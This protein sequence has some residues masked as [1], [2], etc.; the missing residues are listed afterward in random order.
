MVSQYSKVM[1]LSKWK[2]IVNNRESGVLRFLGS[3]RVTDMASVQFS[4]PVISDSLGTHEPQDTRPPCPLPLLES[5]Q[6]LVHWVGEAIQPSHPLS[7]PSPPAFNLSQ[8]PGLFQWVSS[9][10]QVATVLEFQLQ[11][12][13][14]QWTPRTYRLQDGLVGSPCSPRDSQESSPTP[15]FK[16]INSSAMSFLY[17]PTLTSIHDCWKNYSLW[18]FVGKVMSLLFNML[19]RLVITFLPRNKYPLISWQQSP[20]AVLEPKKIKPLT[21][22]IVSS[23]ICQKMMRVD[24][25]IFVFWML[26]FKP[27]FSFPSFT[28]IKRLFSSSLLSAVRVVSSVYLRLLVF[29]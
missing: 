9:S 14:V 10:C 5:T 2:D 12:Q 16:S 4:H 28:F 21:V 3:H 15:Q 8:H 27:T 24:I 25:M 19:S 29:L 22:S 11:H 26:S 13:F 17:S 20:S 7:T 23:S 1:S 18:T 6:T